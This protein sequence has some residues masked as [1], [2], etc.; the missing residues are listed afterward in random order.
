MSGRV[1]SID[2]LQDDPRLV[3]IGTASLRKRDLNV[4]KSPHGEFDAE[5]N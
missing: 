4:L 2:A 5:K 3:Y 1:T